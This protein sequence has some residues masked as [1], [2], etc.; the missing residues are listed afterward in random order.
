MQLTVNE[1]RAKIYEIMSTTGAN[2]SNGTAGGA[3][4]NQRA[5]VASAA[6]KQKT[7]KFMSANKGMTTNG[8]GVD[9]GEKGQQRIIQLMDN[10]NCPFERLTKSSMNHYKLD[11]VTEK[12]QSQQNVGVPY[13]NN[14]GK[15][16]QQPSRSHG[17]DGPKLAYGARMRN[18]VSCMPAVAEAANNKAL[19]NKVGSRVP[20]AQ[21]LLATAQPAN[22]TILPRSGDVMRMNMNNT[23]NS[24]HHQQHQ[25]QQQTYNRVDQERGG[26]RGRATGQT[27]EVAGG[28]AMPQRCY[29]N[30]L[31]VLEE[32]IRR[33]KQEMTDFLRVGN[34]NKKL[35]AI[36][37]AAANKPV[38]AVV[39]QNG[40]L[41]DSLIGG[42]GRRIESKLSCSSSSTT[43]TSNQSLKQQQQHRPISQA[44]R[45]PAFRC[46]CTPNGTAV[47]GL[48][49]S[50][51]V[52]GG[53]GSLFV[54]SSSA[55]AAA[56]G[57][58]TTSMKAGFGVISAT[59]LYKLRSSEIIN[60]S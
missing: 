32:K 13:I 45:K 59:D 38:Q 55:A 4:V 19:T 44:E 26:G 56:G 24:T 51:V 25:Q 21:L 47:N 29:E 22:G 18:K 49:R 60:Q 7:K 12:E 40:R 41:G 30:R 39:L 43:S 52:G 1:Y 14:K 37:A 27:S 57:S 36:Q 5:Q 42:G 34:N 15:L 46:G 11:G 58:A 28:S 9:E 35:A 33:H 6:F 17:C 50:S 10:C 8:H 31:K 48:S 3:G 23:R 54:K 20:P 2:N 16:H 53:S